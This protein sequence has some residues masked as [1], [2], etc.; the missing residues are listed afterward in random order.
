MTDS[1]GVPEHVKGIITMKYPPPRKS[2]NS[3]MSLLVSAADASAYR[4]R[5]K[6][7]SLAGKRRTPLM[8]ADQRV[9]FLQKLEKVYEQ[10]QEQA[11]QLLDILTPADPE[12]AGDG[13]FFCGFCS[14]HFI[15][16][17]VLREHEG[18]KTHKKRRKQ[19]LEESQ[20]MDQ[21]LIS[22]L[23]VG[24]SRETKKPRSG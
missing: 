21:E 20:T 8:D 9:G 17:A 3:Q 15:T 24:Y 10:P 19:V 16:E 18:S 23:A 13:Q 11:R 4:P 1:G 12:I 5:L 22:E 6:R 2:K 14:R 7:R